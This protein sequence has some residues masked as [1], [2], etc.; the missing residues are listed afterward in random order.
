M[1]ANINQAYSYSIGKTDC[2][3]CDDLV[4]LVSVFFERNI[5]RLNKQDSQKILSI[6]QRIENSSNC[7][8]NAVKGE[9]YRTFRQIQRKYK[10]R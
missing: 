9:M 4:V 2:C 5:D 6:L 1:L 8:N 3:K 10:T 7:V